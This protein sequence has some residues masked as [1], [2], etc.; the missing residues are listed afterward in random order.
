MAARRPRPAGFSA[1]CAAE[2]PAIGR[3]G[4]RP[5]PVHASVQRA[6]KDINR[7]FS[8]KMLLRDKF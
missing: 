7:E 4:R 3:F 8:K 1:V 5:P 2:A 6:M